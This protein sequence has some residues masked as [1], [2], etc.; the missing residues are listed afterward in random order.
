MGCAASAVAISFGHAFRWL[1]EDLVCAGALV[2]QLDVTVPSNA[3]ISML[4]G[5]A[6]M[7]RAD[8]RRMLTGCRKLRCVHTFCTARTES[9]VNLSPML[10][11]Y[12]SL[13]VPVV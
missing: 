2:N 7:Q 8:G 3:A 1:E 11:H 10:G 6:A 9:Y 4:T 13:S 12:Q 5:P